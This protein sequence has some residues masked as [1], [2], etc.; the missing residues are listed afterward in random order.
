V[1]ISGNVVLSLAVFS[2]KGDG[3]RKCRWKAKGLN[4]KADSTRT[5]VVLRDV[6][7]TS[8]PLDLLVDNFKLAPLPVAF[9]FVPAGTFIR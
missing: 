4:F 9:A 6:S 3:S 5:T 1:E 2:I 7:P 8:N